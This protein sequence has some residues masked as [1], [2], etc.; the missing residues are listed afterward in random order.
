[1]H[2]R[3]RQPVAILRKRL[4]VSQVAGI[5]RQREHIHFMPRR[6]GPQLMKGANL[7]T[8]VRRIRDAVAKVKNSHNFPK[9]GRRG[10]I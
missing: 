9:F 6:H 4:L 10:R 5:V 7:I 3:H 1:M 2:P 8:L